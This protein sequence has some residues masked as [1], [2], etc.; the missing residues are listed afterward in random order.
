[1]G[2]LRWRELLRADGSN[3]VCSSGTDEIQTKFGTHSSLDACELNLQEDLRFRRW[4]I[5]VKKV[6]CFAKRR[7]YGRSPVRAGEVL[8]GSAQEHGIVL[9]AH[10]YRLSR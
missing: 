6:H 2:D 8:H 10:V 9:E 5:Y 1:M 7:G 4:H 3:R